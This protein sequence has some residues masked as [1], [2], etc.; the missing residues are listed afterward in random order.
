MQ[1]LSK[2]TVALLNIAFLLSLAAILLF[3]Y[4]A[5]Q[6]TTSHLPKD[7]IH[8]PFYAIES[9]R[10]AEKSCLD[11]HGDDGIAPLAENHPPKFRCLFCHK[12]N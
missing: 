10:E 5:P 2:K 3:L 7:E 9:K 6:E 4:L 1:K 11:C 12:R 8:A